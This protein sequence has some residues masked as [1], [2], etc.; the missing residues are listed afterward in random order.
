MQEYNNIEQQD[1]QINESTNFQMKFKS[2]NLRTIILGIVFGLILVF[3]FVKFNINLKPLYYLITIIGVLAYLLI[4]Q[5]LWNKYGLR[6][7]ELSKDEIIL[8][9][10]GELTK[11]Y[12][13]RSKIIEIIK[14]RYIF[15]T[16]VIIIFDWRAYKSEIAKKRQKTK[17]HIS[18]ENFDSKEFA[19]FL[20]K[21]MENKADR[22]YRK[23]KK[24]L[25]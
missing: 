22:L 12:I 14:R 17:I 15:A 13:Q 21:L 1:L 16:S 23:K 20:D 3:L 19:V 10:G 6:S 5:F 7:V 24:K 8:T 4:E 11:E 25:T 2:S 9:R 18:Q